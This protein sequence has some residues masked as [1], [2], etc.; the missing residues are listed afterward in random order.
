[1][2]KISLMT[3]CALVLSGSMAM[4][5]MPAGPNSGP[6]GASGAAPTRDVGTL[7]NAATT[8]NSTSTSSSILEQQNKQVSAGQAEPRGSY[9]QGYRQQATA[10]MDSQASCG[11][12]GRHQVAITDE[13]GFKYD[14]CGNRLNA[15]GHSMA[16][17]TR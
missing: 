7:P 9:G 3:A 1:M 12:P 17:H 2:T 4:A 10:P 8:S 11:G 16:P 15:Q 5:Q 6:G 14:S 13:Y